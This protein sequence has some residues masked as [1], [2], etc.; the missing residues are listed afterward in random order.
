MPGRFF[1]LKALWVVADA[2]LALPVIWHAAVKVII[3]FFRDAQI[4]ALSKL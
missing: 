4:E 2:L 1:A 3:Y